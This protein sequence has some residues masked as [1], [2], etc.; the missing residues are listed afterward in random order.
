MKQWK[1]GALIAVGL[2][3][4]AYP[5]A[6]IGVQHTDA[7]LLAEAFIRNDAEVTRT[8]G[9]VERVTLP[10]FGTFSVEVSGGTGDAVFE[11]AVDADRGKASAFVDLRKRGVWEVTGARVV[12]PAGVATTLMVPGK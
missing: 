1:R 10:L 5:A 6:W 9:A 4:I 11:M 3:V 12:N 8:I 7:Y 2:L